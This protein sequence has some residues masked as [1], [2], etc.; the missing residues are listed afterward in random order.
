MPLD[1]LAKQPFQHQVNITPDLA[2]SVFNPPST[3]PLLRLLQAAK[4]DLEVEL[5][6]P[7]VFIRISGSAFATGGNFSMLIGKAKSRKTFSVSAFLASVVKNSAVLGNIQ[8]SL[9]EEQREVIFF[10]TEQGTYHSQKSARRVL[11]LSGLERPLNFNTYNLRKHGAAKR[12]E[13]IEFAIYNTPNLGFVVIDGIRDLVSS[14]NDEE[15]ASMMS[16]KLLKWT[17][18]LNIHILCVLHQNKGDTNARGHLGT[19]LQNKAESV[20]S[21]TKDTQNNE[22]SIVEAEYCRDKDFEPF[23]FQI[24]ECGLPA[25][26]EHWNSSKGGN[27]RRQALMPADVHVDMHKGILEK[28]FSQSPELKYGELVHQVKLTL[29]ELGTKVGTNKVKEFVQWYQSKEMILKG[30]IEGTS[31]AHYTLNS[32]LV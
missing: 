18:E 23:A 32:K 16:S 21:I 11:R 27:E 8:G 15:Q 31:K 6:A 22:I 14:I 10:D 28:V 19:E 4:V 13:I 1:K 26:V 9:P 24:D 12:L 30:G 3:P 2:S 29:D 25:I 7:L 17:E 20:L 5:P